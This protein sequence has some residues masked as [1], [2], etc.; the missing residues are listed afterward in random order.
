MGASSSVSSP[1][2]DGTQIGFDPAAN[3]SFPQGSVFIKQFDSPD[4]D[5]IETRFLVHGS[6]ARYFGYTYRWR[7]DGSDADL[8]TG[9]ESRLIT[10]DD[11]STLKWDFP[12]RAQCLQ[13]HTEPSGRVLGLRTHQLNGDIR[14][15]SGTTDN[16]LRTLDHLGLFSPSIS[17]QEIGGLRQKL[18]HPRPA[19]PTRRPGAQLPRLELLPLPPARR[20]LRQ[21][22][23]RYTT[24]LTA[25]AT[26]QWW[27]HPR[28]WID[29]QGIIRPRLLE[30]SILHTRM[31]SLGGGRMPPLAKNRLEAKRSAPSPSGSTA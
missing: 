8:L 13:C 28:L 3:W 10:F 5:P 22:D 7:E 21:F 16:Q 29:G 11:G 30:K 18:R 23:T 9:A 27:P 4:G 31:S 20:R 6:D 26:R 19:C 17:E 12:S 1:V 25:P 2:P 14:Y 15:P 24:P